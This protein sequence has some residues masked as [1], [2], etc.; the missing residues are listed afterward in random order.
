MIFVQQFE[1]VRTI[2]EKAKK[3][4][5]L[6]GAGASTESG[7]P[8][9]RSA[10]GLYADANVEMYLSRGYY[11]RSPKEF[12]KHYKEIFQINTFHQYKPNRGHRFL[13]ELEE[14]GKDIT[15]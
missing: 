2:L 1:E 8:D 14:Q 3:I 7:I 5:V 9:F 4:T 15:I 13:A 11:N 12:W 10:N 6:T